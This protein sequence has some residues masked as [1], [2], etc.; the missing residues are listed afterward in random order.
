[1]SVG[2]DD[3][4][5]DRYAKRPSWRE[6][7]RR[8]DRGLYTRLREKRER[9]EG[10]K[11]VNRSPWLKEKYL[12]EVEKL[13]SGKKGQPE[14]EKALKRLKNAYGTRRFTKVAREYVK[15]YGLP[16]DWNTLLLLLEAKDEGVVCETM[17]ALARLTSKKSLLER[18]GFR[19]KLKTLSLTSENEKIKQTAKKLLE[20][21]SA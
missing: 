3:F 21:L 16:E 2:F 10:P 13:F 5:D 6:I 19:A 12:K 8:R 17:E 7:D 11:S 18:Q 9:E 14:H 20:E 15:A 4:E 1:M